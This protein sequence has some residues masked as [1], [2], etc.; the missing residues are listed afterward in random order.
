M[1]WFAAH[2]HF[3]LVNYLVPGIVSFFRFG[4]LR[5]YLGSVAPRSPVLGCLLPSSP[6]FLFSCSP[7]LR[8]LRK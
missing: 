7:S 6:L 1:F 4:V 3:S 8:F 5:D 2:G